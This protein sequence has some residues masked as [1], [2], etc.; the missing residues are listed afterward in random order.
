MGRKRLDKK[1]A[2]KKLFN[3]KSTVFNVLK[4]PYNYFS[5]KSNLHRKIYMKH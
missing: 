2:S 4:V 5:W 3:P 1:G